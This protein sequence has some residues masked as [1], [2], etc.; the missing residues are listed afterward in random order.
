MT[1]SSRDFAADV[2]RCLAEAGTLPPASNEGDDFGRQADAAIAAITELATGAGGARFTAEVLAAVGSPG[3]LRE[4]FGA[5]AADWTLYLA[6]AIATG[7]TVELPAAGSDY[8]AF[9]AALPSGFRWLLHVRVA[10]L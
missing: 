5:D 1:Y 8:A 9:V 4:T 2:M 3:A 6:S 7:S 10:P